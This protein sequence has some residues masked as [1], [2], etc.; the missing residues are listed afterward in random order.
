MENVDFAAIARYGNDESAEGLAKLSV[1][2]DAGGP[3]A[4]TFLAE[5]ANHPAAAPFAGRVIPLSRDQGVAPS[6]H[7]RMAVV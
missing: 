3:N 1:H 7:A 5:Y 4:R 2:V 6:R